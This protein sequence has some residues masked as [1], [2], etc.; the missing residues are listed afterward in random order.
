[1]GKCSSKK[2]AQRA[3]EFIAAVRERD[4]PLTE[5]IIAP[6]LEN[7]M[8]LDKFLDAI[9]IVER[10]N[11]RASRRY[12]KYHA[13]NKMREMQREVGGKGN[14]SDLQKEVVRQVP[15]GNPLRP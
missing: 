2:W 9:F 1:V 4:L 7:D 11:I 12:K 8:K 3:K 5:L 13:R 15:M 14:L 6:F 10:D